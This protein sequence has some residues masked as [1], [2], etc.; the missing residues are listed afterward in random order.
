MVSECLVYSI[1]ILDTL[2]KSPSHSTRCLPS[3]CLSVNWKACTRRSVSSTER[4]TGR[5]FTV[6]CLKFPLS[7]MMNKPLSIKYVQPFSK[8]YQYLMVEP[9][10]DMAQSDYSGIHSFIYSFIQRTTNSIENTF[11]DTVARSL[12]YKK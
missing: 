3:P 9:I 7:S 11:S 10:T 12:I 5:S 4:P 2:L 6:I 1:P 8:L